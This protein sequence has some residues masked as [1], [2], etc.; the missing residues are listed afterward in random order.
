MLK[1]VA[2]AVKLKDPEAVAVPDRTPAGLSV[3]PEGSAPAV[4]ANAKGP[5]PPE[6]VSAWLTGRLANRFRAGTAVIV[7]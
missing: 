1:S 4:T 3:R 6:V 5:T 7:A 2:V